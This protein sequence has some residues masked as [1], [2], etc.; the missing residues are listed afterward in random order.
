MD[1]SKVWK[2]VLDNHYLV[3]RDLVPREAFLDILCRKG[4]LQKEE[5]QWLLKNSLGDDNCRL[6]NLVL[7]YPILRR[8]PD[9]ISTYQVLGHALLSTKQIDVLEALLRKNIF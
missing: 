1:A 9:A 3:S 4:V 7:L 6:T 8:H 5:K 2:P